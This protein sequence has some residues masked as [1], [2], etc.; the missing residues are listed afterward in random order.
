MAMFSMYFGAGNIVFP[1]LI[2]QVTTDQTFWA[3]LGLIITAVGVPFVGLFAITLYNG[4][5][6]Q[7]FARLGKWPAFVI[8]LLIMGCIGPFGAIPRCIALSYANTKMFFDV[9][10]I[11]P[12]SIVACVLIFAATVRK[13]KIMDIV[14]WMLTP[15]FLL[16]IGLIVVMGIVGA[17]EIVDPSALT[18]AGSFVYGLTTGYNTMDLL[19]SFFFCLVV[20]QA[21]HG[22][23]SENG[24]LNQKQLAKNGLYSCLVGAFL[25]AIV[26]IGMCYVSAFNASKLEG[27]QPE[28]LIGNIALHVLGPYAGITTCVAVIIATLTT[29]IALSSIFAEFLQKDVLQE[30]ISYKLSLILTLVITFFVS[31][32]EFSGIVKMLVPIV[33]VIYPLLLVLSIVNIVYKFWG[34]G[35]VKAPIVT[36]IGLSLLLSM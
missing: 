19:G 22:I 24:V 18:S 5:Y 23:S 10:S 29:A 33:Q 32:L 28:L 36:A 21:L 2:G 25:L 17:N 31:T 15:F 11:I 14:G 1:L 35:K 4:D 26:Y 16:S 34:F 8:V 13:T 7:F 9:P 6:K 30:R 27:V 12:F 20:N 3:M